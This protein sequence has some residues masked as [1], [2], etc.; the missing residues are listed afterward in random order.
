MK[1]RLKRR[2]RKVF[3]DKQIAR[4]VRKLGREIR[5]D[6]GKGEVFLLAVLKGTSCFLSDLLRA[7]PGDVGYGFINVIRDVA[8]TEVATATEI[9]YLHFAD[10]AGKNVYLLKDVVSTGV[11]ETYL[12][13]Q[14]REKNP[15]S[16]KLVALIDRPALRTVALE[17]D[18]RVFEADHRGIFLG[19]G[20]EFDEKHANL[21]Y[22]GRV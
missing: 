15:R 12:L 18:F 21:P 1:L 17:A 4:R 20:L 22:I 9:D 19:Y 7:V 6:A 3:S 10:I 5:D 11:I 8:D 14:L 16:L 2:I 13:M